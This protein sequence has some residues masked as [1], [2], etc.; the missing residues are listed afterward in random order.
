MEDSNPL[1][2][3][4]ATTWILAVGIWLVLGFGI[5]D[6]GG[7]FTRNVERVSILH[8]SYASRID[9]FLAQNADS[10]ECKS[11]S[12]WFGGAGIS[13]P[14][15]LM[16]SLGVGCGRFTISQLSI[17]DLS[18]PDPITRFAVGLAYWQ[19]GDDRMAANGWADPLFSAIL[20]N[21]AQTLISED[22]HNVAIAVRL[23]KVSVEANPHC[24]ECWYKLGN[25]YL[26]IPDAGKA[27]RAY[28]EAA[29]LEEV[30]SLQWHLANGQVHLLRGE[31]SQSNAHLRSAVALS[32]SHPGGYYWL[33]RV[34]YSAKGNESC[35][36]AIKLLETAVHLAPEWSTANSM[37]T[38]LQE[39]YFVPEHRYQRK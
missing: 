11:L 2:N 39:K 4:C 17:D 7:D 27:A 29:A 30:D 21:R 15:D 5:R 20:R 37:L 38:D 35:S 31:F 14:F 19:V 8:R 13:S 28:Q 33:A 10:P 23:L 22:H 32:P 16:L 24:R 1:A 9:P 3:K 36:E 18:S 34:L 25:A 26:S 12:S 6:W